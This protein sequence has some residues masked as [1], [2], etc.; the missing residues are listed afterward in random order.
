VDTDH[1]RPPETAAF[2]ARSRSTFGE[3]TMKKL[4]QREVEERLRRAQSAGVVALLVFLAFPVTYYLLLY[5]VRAHVIGFLGFMLRQPG[6]ALVLSMFVIVAAP[7]LLLPRLYDWLSK[8]VAATADL[9][10]PNCGDFITSARDWQI[11]LFTKRCPHC[12]ETIIE[13]SADVG[14]RWGQRADKPPDEAP[15][16]IGAPGAPQPER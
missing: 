4:T 11:C 2:D 10:C 5:V 15:Q 13:P 12:S 7:M 8:I 1:Q 9:A 6:R 14:H 16:A 3:K